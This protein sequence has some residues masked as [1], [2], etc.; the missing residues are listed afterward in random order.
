MTKFLFGIFIGITIMSLLAISKD[1]EE[2]ET[3]SKRK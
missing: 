2:K 3:R 1:S